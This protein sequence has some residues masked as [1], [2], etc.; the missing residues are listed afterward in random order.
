MPKILTH[1]LASCLKRINAFLNLSWS[2]SFR[3]FRMMLLGYLL[4]YGV[5]GYGSDVDF[6]NLPTLLPAVSGVAL[7]ILLLFSKSK[8]PIDHLAIFSLQMKHL[9]L[10]FVFFIFLV[11]RSLSS[12]SREP[13]SDEL[14]YVQL[15]QV[16]SLEVLRRVP[17]IDSEISAGSALRLLSLTLIVFF[18]FLARKF[19][20]GFR[21]SW[22]IGSVFLGTV[23]LQIVHAAFGGWGWGYAKVSWLPF[24][25]T[26]TA[27]GVQTEV[28][29]LTSL[30]LVSVGGVLLYE[31]MYR[32][33]KSTQMRIGIVMGLFLLPIPSIFF[34]SIDHVLYFMVFALPALPYLLRPPKTNELPA[35]IGLLTLGVFFRLPV[36]F[37]LIALLVGW[38]VRS[39]FNPAKFA[40]LGLSSVALA[41]LVP[42][43]LGNL[44]S[45][46]VFSSDQMEAG[47]VLSADSEEIF[48]ALWTQ[49]GALEMLVVLTL[50]LTALAR[51]PSLWPGAS[52]FAILVAFFYFFA[53][54]ASGLVG[55]PKYSVEW[56]TSVVLLGV[57]STLFLSSGTFKPKRIF[58]AI[59]HVVISLVVISG[60]TFDFGFVRQGET[61]QKENKVA[62]GYQ[63]F[64]SANKTS[65]CVPTG[66]VYGVGSE[67]LANRS[68]RLVLETDRLYRMV[69]SIN[70]TVSSSWNKLEEGAVLGLDAV[71]C[72]YGEKS[73]FSSLPWE[74][75]SSTKM[76]L[77][78][79]SNEDIVVLRRT[80]PR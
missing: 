75:W 11:V 25:L 46:P 71:N 70:A 4:T 62:I 74:G 57:L 64:L 33:T 61:R 35:L 8:L 38:A 79:G 65:V 2:L 34:S 63:K 12:I 50:I 18:L 28:F 44:V 17:E 53:L 69:S 41:M 76:S 7:G 37:I 16:H 42:Y 32:L 66:V 77:I 31:T 29:R 30:A 67:I 68:L 22:A 43:L 20:F 15:S 52:V 54:G 73:A 49:I 5:Y 24:L 78:P 59:P 1:F 21:A 3:P 14:S 45:P 58:R 40:E 9:C 23:L 80:G 60:L 47:P 36:A 19:I 26:T 6:L 51:R 56:G 55:N 39:K 13:T 27:F 72:I 10:F 48:G